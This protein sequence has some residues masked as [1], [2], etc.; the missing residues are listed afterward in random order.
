MPGGSLEVLLRQVM[1]NVIAVAKLLAAAKTAEGGPALDLL[2]ALRPE[3]APRIA[4]RPMT[5]A[6]VHTT[7]E[8]PF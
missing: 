4:E 2:L 7:P 1:A 5:R 3:N 6:L 8:L